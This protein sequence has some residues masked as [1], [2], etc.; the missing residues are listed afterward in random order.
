[1]V[2]KVEKCFVVGFS[3]IEKYVL[4]LLVCPLNR[5]YLKP[6][7][8]RRLAIFRVLISTISERFSTIFLHNQ[9]H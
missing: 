5:I 1:M 2:V 6:F 3:V 8:R 9:K 7:F 4:L